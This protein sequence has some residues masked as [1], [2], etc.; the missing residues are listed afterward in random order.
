MKSGYF[1]EILSRAGEVQHRH[2][3][4]DLPIRIGRAYDNDFILDDVHTAA[5]HAMVD[6]NADGK[7]VILDLGSKNG[8]VHQGKRQTEVTIDGHSVIRMGQTSLRIRSADFVV[9]E[10]AFDTSNYGWEGWPPALAGFILLCLISLSGTWLTD[11]EKFAAVRYLMGLAPVLAAILIW[12]GI[13]A[14]A[15]RLF[16]GH[17]RFGRHVFIAASGM[18]IAQLWSYLSSILGFAF[19]WEFL[20]RYGSHILVMIGAAGLYF[21]LATIKPRHGRGLVV[22]TVILSLLGS[23]LMLMTNYQRSGKL[24]DEFYMTD[25]FSPS[26]RLS[27]NHSVDDFMS[28]AN[29]LKA[30]VDSERSKI[31]D[32]GD[33]DNDAE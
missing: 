16:G 4:T 33:T 23:G 10:E 13:W 5:H 19:S 17:T 18:L 29:A 1:I 26:M 32:Q 31:V 3:V 24:A 2:H 14:F 7:L 22:T 20:S 12:C 8:L 25:L 6:A 21:H 30:D 11:T 27:K 28:A 15:N 9:D